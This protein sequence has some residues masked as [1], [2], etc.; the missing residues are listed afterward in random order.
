MQTETIVF[1]LGNKIKF[2]SAVL[3]F[4]SRSTV[5]AYVIQTTY[6]KR[7]GNS[8]YHCKFGL[9]E[10]KKTRRIIVIDLF[11]DDLRVNVDDM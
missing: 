5:P 3:I 7:F 6:C 8:C 10:Y 9:Y 2:S 11:E 4:Y 1:C